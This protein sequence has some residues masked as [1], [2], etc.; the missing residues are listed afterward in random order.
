MADFTREIRELE[1]ILASGA[2]EVVVDGV[3]VVRDFDEIR[4]RLQDLRAQDST[5]IAAGQKRP[6]VARINLSGF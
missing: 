2:R 5:A 3:K 6:R 1:E 4:R